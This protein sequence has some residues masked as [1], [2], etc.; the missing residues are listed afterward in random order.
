MEI[1][2]N[3]YKGYWAG[4][5]CAQSAEAF[6]AGQKATIKVISAHL[7]DR[8]QSYEEA[9]SEYDWMDEIISLINR[10]S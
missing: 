6:I 4:A 10:S 8:P 3:L 2:E 7:A 9:R 5:D 1:N